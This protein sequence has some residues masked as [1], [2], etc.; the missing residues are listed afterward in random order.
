MHFFGIDWVGINAENGRK[1]LLS[2]IYIGVVLLA[3]VILRA[4][5][6]LVLGRTDHAT[7]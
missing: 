2:I 3:G 7:I 4:L 5:V 1:L 6:G